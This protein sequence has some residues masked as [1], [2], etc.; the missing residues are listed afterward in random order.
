[1]RLAYFGYPHVGG[2]FSVFR[3]LRVG[4]APKGMD[5]VWV[6]LGEDAQ[7]AERAPAWR[8]E[9]ATGFAVPAAGDDKATTSAFL[10]A[11]GRGGFDGVIV[12]VLADRLQTNAVRYLPDDLLRIMIVHNIT[13]G[14]YAAARSIRDDVH[15]TVGVSTRIWCDLVN[16]YGF[17][18]DRTMMIPNATDAKPHGRL[19]ERLAGRPLRVLFV[20]RIE[21]QSKGV[22][23]L[24][25]IMRRLPGDATLTVVGSGPDLPA[26]RKRL[27]PFGRRVCCPGA[28]PPESVHAMYAD[29][30]V[31]LAP[32]RYE[33]FQI[34]L[35]EAMSKGCV[36]VAS[37]IRGVTDMIVETGR[38][39][40]LFPV[41]DT[42][43]AA[44]AIAGLADP[45]VFEAVS[46]RATETAAQRFRLDMMA[47][48]YASLIE[49]VRDNRPTI[50]PARD[51]DDWKLSSGLKAG[52]RTYLPISV[53]NWVRAV[54]ERAA[55]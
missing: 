7:A 30:D 45:K 12:N 32:S 17:K 31:L 51:I 6:G 34:V 25:S 33:G 52:L 35:V 2:T 4:L 48:R 3:H 24:P 21:D 38:N 10:D 9:A 40:Y 16:R 18:P 29:H 49:W 19:Y 14:T 41:G 1:M 37:R 13:P 22:F 46:A 50:D 54:S 23:W 11:I 53:K 15:A 27:A 44:R 8:S 28:L 5:V 36:P 55:V 42:A 26:L 20:G 39:G 47:D 43:A